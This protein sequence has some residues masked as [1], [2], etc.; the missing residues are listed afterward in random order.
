MIEASK[1][2]KALDT[3]NGTVTK[4]LTFLKWL[5]HISRFGLAALFLFTAGAKLAIAK[6]FATNVAELLSASGFNYARWMWPTTVAVITA[7]VITAVLLLLPRTVRIG[8]LAAAALLLGF[9][10][11]ALYY[12]YALHGEPLECGCF[13]GVIASQLGV[14]TTLRNLALLVPVLIVFF[15]YRR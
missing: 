7:E 1:S 14:K 13:G 5:V 6:T 4:R 12:G 9:A 11:Y 10:G 2:I 8:A 3:Q 15:G